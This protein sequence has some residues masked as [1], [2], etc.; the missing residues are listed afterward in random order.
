MYRYYAVAA[1]VL[2]GLML[3]VG[4]RADVLY[5]FSSSSGSFSITNPTILTTS[6]TL[7]FTPFTLEGGSFT[8]GSALF[9]GNNVCFLFATSNTGENCG[10]SDTSPPATQFATGTFQNAISPGTY[11]EVFS[12]GPSFPFNGLICTASNGPPCVVAT[13]WTLTISNVVTA[14]PEPSSLLLLGTGALGLFGPIR[15][16]LLPGK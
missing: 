13:D 11:S 1:F 2:L 7:S 4:A 5:S 10:N 14:T 16:K 8:Y 15:R 9:L 6:A 3:P 12:L